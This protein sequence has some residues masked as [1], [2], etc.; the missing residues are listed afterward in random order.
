MIYEWISLLRGI[1]LAFK[2]L[3]CLTVSLWVLIA[4]V[5]SAA[6]NLVM[7]VHPYRPHNELKPMFQP[8]AEYLTTKLGR[9]VEVR[10][11]DSYQSHHDAILAGDAEAGRNCINV[12]QRESSS[13]QHLPGQMQWVSQINKAL[14]DD[15]FVLYAQPIANLESDELI[16]KGIEILIQAELKR[17][18]IYYGQ[19]YSIAQPKPIKDYLTVKNEKA[20]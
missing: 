7:G 10:I 8:L 1:Q 12:Y 3:A 16:V 18:G 20:I 19:G 11:G 6:E 2:L 15:R 5:S 4:S 9:E 17:I 14:Q 13:S